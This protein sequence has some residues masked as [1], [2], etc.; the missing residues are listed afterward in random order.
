MLKRDSRW[1][2]GTLVVDTIRTIKLISK[3]GIDTALGRRRPVVAVFSM[4]HYCNF[5]CPMCPF[6]D[7][8]KEGQ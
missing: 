3:W 1:R 6:G 2:S 5:Y 4:T 8:D 7:P